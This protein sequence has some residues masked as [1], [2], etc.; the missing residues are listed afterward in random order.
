MIDPHGYDI[1]DRDHIGR[2][3]DEAI[4][5]FGDVDHAI[6]FDAD[7]DEG[8]EVHDIADGSLQFHARFQIFH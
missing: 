8:A 3:F 4:A 1:A 7:V 5:Q 6:L 2:M